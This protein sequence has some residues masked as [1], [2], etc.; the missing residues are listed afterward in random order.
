MQEAPV[1]P[2]RIVSSVAIRLRAA[3][4]TTSATV[5]IIP[6]FRPLIVTRLDIG[7]AV[8]RGTTAWL[9]ATDEAG[10]EGWVWGGLPL[11]IEGVKG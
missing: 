1:F 6:P 10:R 2:W 9:R 3:P 11:R 7:E 8:N 4:S 5:Q